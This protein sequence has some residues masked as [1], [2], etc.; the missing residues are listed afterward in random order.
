MAVSA[1]FAA[2]AKL[3]DGS[4]VAIRRL[5]PGDYDAVVCLASQLTDEERYLR[6]FTVHP[7]HI[8]EWALSLTAPAAGMVA[9]ANYAELSRPGW[10]EI[11]VVVAHEQHERGVGTALLR[12]LGHIARSAGQHRFV[13]D[14]LTENCAM[15]RVIS[16]L[17][18]P[19]TQHCDGSVLS[20]EFDLDQTNSS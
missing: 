1:E 6:F 4:T 20:V 5:S 18:W 2:T 8:G 19:T 10:A 14:V 13:A 16:D 12:A 3:F 7:T 9:L 11:A 15:R 17:G